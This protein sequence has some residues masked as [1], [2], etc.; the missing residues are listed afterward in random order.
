MCETADY[1]LVVFVAET[2]FVTLRTCD[3]TTV[4][5]ERHLLVIVAVLNKCI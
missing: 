3:A 4:R 2:F 5:L 1:V